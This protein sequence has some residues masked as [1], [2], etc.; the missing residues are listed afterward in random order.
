MQSEFLSREEDDMAALSDAIIFLSL[1]LLAVTVAT[2]VLAVSFLG[3]AIEQSSEEEA[4]IAKEQAEELDKTIRETQKR[5]DEAKESGEVDEAS[6]ELEGYKGKKE[7]FEKRRAKALAGYRLLTVREGILYP[8][9]VLLL[10]LAFAAA[11]KPL[12]TVSGPYALAFSY[13]LLI[14]GAAGIGW[15]CYRLYRSLVVVQSVATIP[16][17]VQLKRTVKAFEIAMERHEEKKRPMLVLRFTEPGPPF[18]FEPSTDKVIE[19]HVIMLHGDVAKSV[20][21]EFYAPE[22]FD[23]PGHETSHRPSYAFAWPHALTANI[24]L[25]ELVYGRACREKLT[26]KTPPQGGTYKLG[27]MMSSI[28]FRTGDIVF[29]E[30]EVTE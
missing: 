12:T 8:G 24:E 4:R 19:F 10:S 9:A 16:E 3:R 29:F 15:V 2:F 27:Y 28:G 25:G 1:T 20:A 17:E 26:I 30:V 6:R 14:I 7:Q 18:K 5:L 23:F 13:V 11:A 21:V 22:G